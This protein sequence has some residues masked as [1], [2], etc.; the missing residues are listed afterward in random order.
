MQ[1]DGLTYQQASDVVFRGGR[2]AK[3]PGTGGGG[4][5][6]FAPTYNLTPG[7]KESIEKQLDEGH[8][9]AKESILQEYDR[10]EDNRRRLAF[11]E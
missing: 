8:K 1:R 9:K 4:S 5:L 2:G 6:Q 7:S 3:Q 11:V 10:R